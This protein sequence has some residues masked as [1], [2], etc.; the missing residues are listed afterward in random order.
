MNWFLEEAHRIVRAKHNIQAPAAK[1]QTSTKRPAPLSQVPKTLAGVPGPD[2]P[3]DVGND[4]F[5]DIDKLSGLELEDAV[6]K[7]SPAARAKYLSA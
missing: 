4:E 7:L 1:T 6:A 2:G 5:Q 3:G